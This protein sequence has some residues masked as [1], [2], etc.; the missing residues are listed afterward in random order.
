MDEEFSG[1]EEDLWVEKCRFRHARASDGVRWNRASGFPVLNAI[2]L[3]VSLP[4]ISSLPSIKMSLKAGV[5]AFKR[6]YLF[7]P[8]LKASDACRRA[9]PSYWCR[10]RN[11]VVQGHTKA[12]LFSQSWSFKQPAGLLHQRCLDGA[13]LFG[14]QT[15]M[16]VTASESIPASPWHWAVDNS[17]PALHCKTGFHSSSL[18]H[19]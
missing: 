13:E 6:L 2:S 17:T 7:P 10:E 16:E 9:S 14:L 12:V 11:K 15:P 5:T 1:W 8:N 18:K 3:A 4:V 19:R